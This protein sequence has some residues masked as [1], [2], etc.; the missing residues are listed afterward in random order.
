MG[1][2]ELINENQ[3]I[4]IDTQ[5]EHYIANETEKPLDFL[6]ISQPPTNNDRTTL[7]K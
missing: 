2:T 1:K 6:V 3:G 7:E 5:M 4:L